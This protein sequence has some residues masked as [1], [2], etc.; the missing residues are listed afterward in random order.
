MKGRCLPFL[1]I[2]VAIVALLPIAVAA[3]IRAATSEG[4]TPPG[5]P[6]GDPDLQGVWDYATMVS[7]ERP[8]EFVGK[9]LLTDTEVAERE[10]QLTAQLEASNVTERMPSGTYN[11]FWRD[12]GR[13]SAR[14]SLIV[15][16]PDGKI[17]P[18]T[19]EAAQRRAD[20]PEL[21]FDSHERRPLGE[22]CL[23]WGTAGPPCSQ[24]PTT[25]TFTSC[26]PLGAC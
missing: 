11:L 2:A 1:L 7:L 25:A 23:L 26:R 8:A 21:G 13:M 16:P 6:W 4:W 9:Q 10:A 12:P 3:Q 19:P 20:R 17:P 15:D 5:T 18:L 24:V 14:T 22:R